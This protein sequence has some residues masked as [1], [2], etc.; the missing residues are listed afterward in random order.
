MADLNVAL[1]L[2]FVDQATRPARDA[3]GKVEGMGARAGKLAQ[4]R[5]SYLRQNRAA[6]IAEAGAL[7]ATGWAFQRA[8][9]PAIAFEEPMAEVGK[10]VDFQAPDGLQALGRDIQEL[11][12]S[13]GLPMAAEGIADIVAAAGS[14]GFIDEALPDAEKRAELIAFADAA[15]KMGTAF[16]IS[17]QNAGSAMAVWRK[18]LGL[19]QADA[20]QLGDAVNHLSNKMGVQA[21]EL[22]NLIQRQGGYAMS[23]GLAAEEVAALGTTFLSADLGP[24]VAAT[25]LKNFVGALTSGQAA[26]KAQSSV[27]GQLGLDAVDLSK[28]MQ[29]DAKGA[30]LDVVHALGKLDAAER[31]AALKMLFGEEVIGSVTP[32]VENANLLE[33]AFAQVA[34]KA[35]YAGS[36]TKEYE[37]IAETTR[38]KLTILSNETAMLAV[39][40]GTA[41]LPAMVAMVEAVSPAVHAFSDFAATHPAVIQLG[42]SA[43]AGLW[44]LRAAVLAVS[45]VMSPLALVLAAVA[46]A[47]FVIYQNWDNIASY[48]TEKIDA[49]RAA[50]QDGLLNGVLAALA[51]FNPFVLMTDAAIGLVN[52]FTDWDIA[53]I[54]ERI[55]AAFSI[56][57]YDA[58]VRMLR[59]AWDGMLSILGPMVSAISARL[60]AI[61]PGWMLRAWNWVAGGESSSAAPPGR[62]IGG[63]VRAGQIYRWMEEGEELFVP[64]VDGN[65]VSNRELSALRAGGRRGSG[66]P[67]TTN[68]ITI[69]AAQ[70][71]SPNDVARA[72]IREIE[73]R[74][75]S[76]RGAELH[77][78]GAYAV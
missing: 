24:E 2:R 31:P 59:S 12:T 57:L 8:M 47:A 63:A 71:M 21:G 45:L 4:D 32:L 68:N 1:I 11:V 6:Q 13:G 35:A 66:G 33:E 75:S 25:A 64:R 23:V 37:G 41:L 43:A 50:F 58:G 22:T 60:A 7:A 20:L 49:V 10:V 15:A 61:V 30:I 40:M 18:V 73:R 55:R 19:T 48:F 29:V 78:G 26:T 14:A 34:D 28:R 5:V 39:V 53:G 56:D 54:S 44:A 70:G 27:L 9:G 16:G 74:A 72:V 51:A 3:L 77:D 36:M 67:V 42:A 62:A 76:S 69:H 17:A 65:I 52:Y 38:S 46:G